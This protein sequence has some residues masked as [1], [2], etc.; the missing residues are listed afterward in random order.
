LAVDFILE[1]ID[2]KKPDLVVMGTTGASGL[3]EMIIGSNTSTIV[4][5]AKCPVIA[6]PEKKIFSAI[7]SITYATNYNLTDI[8][9]LEKL[10]EIAKLFHA[11]ITLLHVCY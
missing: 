2:K 3:K 6:V 5:K 10:V 7:K 9:A 1:T 8:Y 4:E 11:K